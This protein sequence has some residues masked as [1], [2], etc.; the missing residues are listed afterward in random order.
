MINGLSNFQASSSKL[1]KNLLLSKVQEI[2]FFAVFWEI[3]EVFKKEMKKKVFDFKENN[4]KIEK[5]PEILS[6][7]SINHARIACKLHNETTVQFNI[8]VFDLTATRIVIR[9]WIAIQKK[10]WIA[11]QTRFTI[12]NFFLDRNPFGSRSRSGSPIRIDN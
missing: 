11:I 7:M 4:E 8:N 5:W 10:I 6:F 9:A 12:Q 2:P 3:Q 1:C